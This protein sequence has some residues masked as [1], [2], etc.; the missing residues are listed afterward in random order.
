MTLLRR[1]S[2]VAPA[3]F[4]SL[5]SNSLSSMGT[6]NADNHHNNYHGSYHDGTTRLL[7]WRTP[8]LLRRHGG[9]YYRGGYWHDH[10]NNEGWYPCD[11]PFVVGIPFLVPFFR[12]Q[13]LDLELIQAG[14]LYGAKLQVGKQTRLSKTFP[15]NAFSKRFA[16]QL[17]VTEHTRKLQYPYGPTLRGAPRRRTSQGSLPF[18]L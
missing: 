7:S 15:P 13:S 3:G 17:G 12:F 8:R 1:S 16:F 11:S 4:V 2:I 6:A 5:I 10:Y 18:R 14:D 9:R